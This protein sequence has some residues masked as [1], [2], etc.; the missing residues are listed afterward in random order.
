MED[1]QRLRRS[2]EFGVFQLNEYIHAFRGS[3]DRARYV[4]FITTAV[5]L[6]MLIS[7]WNYQ[8]WSW[9]RRATDLYYDARARVL[10]EEWK[11][12]V[13]ETQQRE[14]ARKR[15][16]AI[17]ETIPASPITEQSASDLRRAISD[18]DRLEARLA[19]EPLRETLAQRWK[20]GAWNDSERDLEW[21]GKQAAQFYGRGVFVPVP[22]LGSSLHVND[23]AIIGGVVLL[24]LTA[25][26]WIALIRQ[27][28]NLYLALYKI[29]VIRRRERKPSD[30]DSV[31]NLMYH[32]L[33]MAQVLSHPPTLARWNLRVR[34]YIIHAVGALTVYFAPAIVHGTIVTMNCLTRERAYAVW[35]SDITHIRLGFQVL[36]TACIATFC[37]LAFTYARS[38]ERRWRKSFFSINPGLARIEQRSWAEWVGL[39]EGNIPSKD[40]RRLARDLTYNLEVI[41]RK[42]IEVRRDRNGRRITKEL[43][44]HQHGITL[45]GAWRCFREMWRWSG[46][47]PL[48]TQRELTKAVN[49]LFVDCAGE[50]NDPARTRL[51]RIRLLRNRLRL[52]G[53]RIRMWHIAIKADVEYP[54]V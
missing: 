35:T 42:R 14:V 50:G 10:A 38:C 45:R 18:L 33:A 21:Y 4:I 28:E 6:L 9:S 16:D 8:G 29:D 41:P 36:I 5:S 32:A 46:S 23:M 54:P 2:P 31:S 34:H 39:T 27:H 22:G 52:D 15:I 51:R 48:I 30:G 43:D 37:A 7:A 53:R 40:L 19:S 17:V 13:L 20:F 26:L 25:L 24:A 1:L 47:T 3:S 11:K 12:I 49:D 44:L